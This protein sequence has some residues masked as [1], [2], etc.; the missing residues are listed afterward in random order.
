LALAAL[1][2]VVFGAYDS[3]PQYAVP[4]LLPQTPG[5]SIIALFSF[6]NLQY[7]CV[8]CSDLAFVG[9]N[10]PFKDAVTSVKVEFSRRYQN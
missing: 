5:K 3:Y 1:A 9:M 6:L 10:C 8:T 4:S 2:L 7:D